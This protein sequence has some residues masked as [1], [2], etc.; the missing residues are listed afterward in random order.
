MM[1]WEAKKEKDN[2][3]CLRYLLWDDQGLLIAEIN[4]WYDGWLLKVIKISYSPLGVYRT[5]EQAKIAAEK[6]IVMEK[7]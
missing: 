6:L 2:S 4:Q 5:I 7:L 3:H 1:N